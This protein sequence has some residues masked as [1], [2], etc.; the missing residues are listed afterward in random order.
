MT[1]RIEN[2]QNPFASSSSSAVFDVDWGGKTYDIARDGEQW[3]ISSI[4]FVASPIWE[5]LRFD[6]ADAA[7]EWCEKA[8]AGNSKG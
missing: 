2:T 5:D 7:T 6:T 4:T 3:K 8:I 1:D